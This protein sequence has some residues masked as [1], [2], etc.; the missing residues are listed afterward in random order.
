MIVRPLIGL[1]ADNKPY[2]PF[3]T[4]WAAVARRERRSGTVI[5]PEQYLSRAQALHALTMGGAVFCGVEVQ[6][7][8]LEPE[9]L[10]DL[11]VLSDDPL[12]MP[13]ENLPDLHAH[14]TFVGGQTVYDSGVV[15]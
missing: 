10:D 7:G 2:N 12:Q 1:G 13:E 15:R 9:K 6:Q 4:L 11:A 5:G 3:H 14:L 8:S